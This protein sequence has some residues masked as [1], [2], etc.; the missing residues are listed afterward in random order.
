MGMSGH[1][2]CLS[3]YMSSEHAQINMCAYCFILK[4]V[5]ILS[6]KVKNLRQ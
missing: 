6:Y 2:I 4:K 1:T 5:R 3:V